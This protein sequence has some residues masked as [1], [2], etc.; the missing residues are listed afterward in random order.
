MIN[1]TGGG[2]STQFFF[3]QFKIMTG[4]RIMLVSSEDMQQVIT[5]VIVG[6]VHIVS[7]N[8]AS[9]LPHIRA[10]RL[11]ALGFTMLRRS[12]SAPDIPTIA[13]SGIPG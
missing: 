5:N 1:G 2:S 7:E 8:A 12:T 4:T 11:R 3:E 9:I 10:G 13:E 6:Q